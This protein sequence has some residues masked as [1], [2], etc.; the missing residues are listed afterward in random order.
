MMTPK[1]PAEVKQMCR[2]LKQCGSLVWRKKYQVAAFDSMAV[3]IATHA[4]AALEQQEKEIGVLKLK[5]EEAERCR[6][7][8]AAACD[9]LDAELSALKS[10]K[11]P[12]GLREAIRQ[13][14]NTSRRI[15]LHDCVEAV[16][17]AIQ[18]YLGHGI[19]LSDEERT[20]L[21]SFCSKFVWS[22]QH[23]I[24]EIFGRILASKATEPVAPTMP[25]EAVELAK[26]IQSF[27]SA[28][29]RLGPGDNSMLARWGEL[30]DAILAK[31]QGPGNS[32]DRGAMQH[33][34]VHGDVGSTPTG[35]IPL[36]VTDAH[37]DNDQS[38]VKVEGSTLH[39]V[40]IETAYEEMA[41]LTARIAELEKELVLSR[42]GW[43]KADEENVNLR[44]AFADATRPV[45]DAEVQGAITKYS[46]IRMA[47]EDHACVQVLI[48]AARQRSPQFATAWYPVKNSQGAVM[49]WLPDKDT[50]ERLVANRW[51]NCHVGDPTIP[52]GD[53]LTTTKEG[54]GREI[55]EILRNAKAE[56]SG[57]IPLSEDFRRD[58][59]A[60]IDVIAPPPSPKETLPPCPL[61]GNAPSPASTAPN[62]FVCGTKGCQISKMDAMPASVW[63]KLSGG[64][65]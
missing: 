51:L 32:L 56:S 15:P 40:E 23:D 57:F 64:V 12:E 36:Q 42:K 44:Q 29:T 24:Q 21:T 6:L 60:A 25:S 37:G 54:R 41:R 14:L 7:N 20:K 39:E 4:I 22:N 34:A 61:C 9:K 59:I 17:V 8:S 35:P 53:L 49:A 65:M 48:R 11:P 26:S 5:V 28:T 10:P 55:V 18:P 45:D 3:F 46:S 43:A 63:F 13:G 62:Q 31:A 38:T 52:P 30:A 27:K 50:A 2:D 47:G 1:T 16:L 33:A 19:V 58:L